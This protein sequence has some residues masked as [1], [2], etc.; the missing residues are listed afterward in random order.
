MV[1]VRNVLKFIVFRHYFGQN[2]LVRCHTFISTF[3]SLSL[4]LS[5]SIRF[6]VYPVLLFSIWLHLNWARKTLNTSFVRYY[7]RFMFRS[8]VGIVVDLSIQI[9][10]LN[11]SHK[12]PFPFHKIC[13]ASRIEAGIFSHEWTMFTTMKTFFFLVLFSAPDSK[14]LYSQIT[15]E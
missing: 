12:S 15:F 2:G 14:R 7:S 5:L 6:S 9:W 3:Y 8:Y 4:S 13:I 11:V 10:R 1:D